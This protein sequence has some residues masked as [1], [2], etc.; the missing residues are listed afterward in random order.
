MSNQ[1]IVIAMTVALVSA[2]SAEVK[3]ASVNLPA[4]AAGPLG[5]GSERGFVFRVSQAPEAAEIANNFVRAIQQLNGTLGTPQTPVTQRASAGP[6][7]DGSYAR[8]PQLRHDG[9]E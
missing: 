4:S 5:S 1:G 7:A 6:N 9:L 8:R 2:L 3:A